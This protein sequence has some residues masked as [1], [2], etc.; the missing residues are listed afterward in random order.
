LLKA[1]G[2]ALDKDSMN[3]HDLIIADE[4]FSMFNLGVTETDPTGSSCGLQPASLR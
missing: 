1:G 3:M 4:P 2:Q